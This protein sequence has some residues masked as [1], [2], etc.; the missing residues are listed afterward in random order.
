MKRLEGKVA[1]VT[2][3]GGGIGSATAL[4]L[5]Q[6]GAK[7][8]C[9]DIN[10]DAAQRAVDALNGNGLAVEFDAQNSDSIEAM[11]AKTVERYGASIFSITIPPSPTR[12]P[13]ARTQPRSISPWRSGKKPST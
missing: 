2:G 7:V 8:V 11:V 12:R 4:R 1:I 5:V 13:S 9:A 6:E 10:L 3:G